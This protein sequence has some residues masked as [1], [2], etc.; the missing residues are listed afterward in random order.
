M[1]L[2][3]THIPGELFAASR[4]VLCLQGGLESWHLGEVGRV[5]SEC[6]IRMQTSITGGIREFCREAA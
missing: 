5:F 3:R 2:L 1:S 6:C 4:G